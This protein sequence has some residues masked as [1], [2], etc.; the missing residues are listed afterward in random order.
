MVTWM[1]FT[2]CLFGLRNTVLV[3]LS[4][5][6][7]YAVHETPGIGHPTGLPCEN[8]RAGARGLDFLEESEARRPVE[9]AM[10]NDMQRGAS[11]GLWTN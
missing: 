1:K 2:T 9:F 4:S 6:G 3:I 7:A 11:C 8:A 10:C 5:L